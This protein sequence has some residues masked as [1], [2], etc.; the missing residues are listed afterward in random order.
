M[1]NLIFLAC[2][3]SLFLMIAAC[4][5]KRPMVYPDEKTQE[6]G[7]EQVRADV[8][9]C[10]RRAKEADIGKSKAGEVAKTTATGAGVGAAAGAAAGAIYGSAGLGAAQ[11]AVGGAVAGI[12][13]G[14]L[15]NDL[16]LNQKHYVEECL[17]QKGYTNIRWR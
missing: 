15:R 9:D 4:G 3:A 14:M 11:G 13:G 16:D 5:P 17:R 6:V 10:I 2:L 7:E 1:R 8:E 12:I